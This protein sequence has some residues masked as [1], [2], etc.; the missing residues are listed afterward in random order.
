MQNFSLTG[1]ATTSLYTLS[2]HDA[3]PIFGG[4]GLLT[5]PSTT[6]ITVNGYVYY[7]TRP[8]SNA[9]TL[10]YTSNYYSYFYNSAKIGR[11]SCRERVEHA[12]YAVDITRTDNTTTRAIMMST[13]CST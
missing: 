3:L 9:G 10:N 8:I 4:S 2:L 12:G 13:A 6:T 1:T 11:A 7:D 5:I